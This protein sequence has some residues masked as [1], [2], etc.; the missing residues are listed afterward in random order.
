MRPSKSSQSSLRD[1]GKACATA[2]SP[3]ILNTPPELKDQVTGIQRIDWVDALQLYSG[4]QVHKGGW[5][6]LSNL[7]RSKSLQLGPGHRANHL[8]FIEVRSLLIPHDCREALLTRLW[9]VNAFL[10]S[11]LISLSVVRMDARAYLGL[12]IRISLEDY[13]LMAWA[14]GLGVSICRHRI[15]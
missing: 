13:M 3:S 2:T 12:H 5:S 11:V 9:E 8:H 4:T 1:L 14:I 10:F 15:L 6:A 7:Y